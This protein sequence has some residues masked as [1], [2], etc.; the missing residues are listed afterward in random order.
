MVKKMLVKH[1]QLLKGRHDY[2]HCIVNKKER[3]NSLPLRKSDY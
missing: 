3:G 1:I 2:S